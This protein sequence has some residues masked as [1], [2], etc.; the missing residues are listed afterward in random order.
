MVSAA[1]PCIMC[2]YFKVPNF[3][4]GVESY[5][6]FGRDKIMDKRKFVPATCS[7]GSPLDAKER[8]GI[9]YR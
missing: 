2:Q 6:R 5:T 9:I 8:D 1:T 4:V 7:Q 3:S